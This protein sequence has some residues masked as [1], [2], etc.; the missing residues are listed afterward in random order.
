M[1]HLPSSRLILWSN[2][3]RHI[4]DNFIDSFVFFSSEKGHS[5]SEQQWMSAIDSHFLSKDYKDVSKK[6]FSDNF[7][8]RNYSDEIIVKEIILS[9]TYQQDIDGAISDMKDSQSFVLFCFEN[10][11]MFNKGD[12]KNYSLYGRNR[13]TLW[14]KL[15][16]C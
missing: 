3:I 11:E 16:K 15:Y 2:L 14:G 5:V 8:V 4:V 10:K 12:L 9:E 6:Y 1:Q 7:G 13:Q